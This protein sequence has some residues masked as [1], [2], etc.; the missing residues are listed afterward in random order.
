MTKPR[1]TSVERAYDRVNDRLEAVVDR[2]ISDPILAGKMLAGPSVLLIA[3]S[4]AICL[5]VWGWLADWLILQ[6]GMTRGAGTAIFITGGITSW[7]VLL[8][9]LIVRRMNRLVAEGRPPMRGGEWQPRAAL[10]PE[11]GERRNDCDHHFHR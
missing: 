9:V 10:A 6:W 8:V 4:F 3:V 7:M 1:G 2:K 11:D 5:M